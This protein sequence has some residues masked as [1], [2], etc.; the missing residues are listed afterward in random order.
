MKHRL[1][2]LICLSFTLFSHLY[3]LEIGS[4]FINAPRTI[5]PLLD[6][7][8]RM[9]LIDLYDSGLQ[10]KVVNQ[11]GG[12]TVL[13]KKTKDFLSLQT[14]KS[15][16]WTIRLFSL[17]N[18]DSFILCA[19]SVS[20][21]GVSTDVQTYKTD[22]SKRKVHIP[23]PA[24]EEFVQLPHSYIPMTQQ[25]LTAS[26][27]YLPVEVAVNDSTQYLIYNLDTSGLTQEYLKEC[28]DWLIPVVYQWNGAAFIK[29]K[30]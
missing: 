11:Y 22:W 6:K 18:G 19:H 17:N 13:L 30:E 25:S 5:L 14:T 28:K 24:Q 1:Y 9:D 15:G 23:T 7:T 8:S 29:I 26:L 21:S 16:K 4:L 20:A 12:E 3:A 2:I 10:A 27:K